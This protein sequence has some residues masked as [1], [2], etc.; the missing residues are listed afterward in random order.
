MVKFCNNLAFDKVILVGKHFE[1]TA[2]TA[3]NLFV[4]GSTDL[5]ALWL[6]ENM[7]ATGTLMLKG[8]RGMQLEKL[9]PLFD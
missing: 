2:K 4:F 5:A 7:P 6:S 9:L 1:E 8:S 3:G